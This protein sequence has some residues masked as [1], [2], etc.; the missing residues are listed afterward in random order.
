MSCSWILNPNPDPCKTMF[1]FYIIYRIIFPCYLGRAL[2]RLAFSALHFLYM[3]EKDEFVSVYCGY[4]AGPIIIMMCQK[5]KQTMQVQL[6]AVGIY[7]C[8]KRKE[9]FSEVAPLSWLPPV[10]SISL[11]ASGSWQLS[12]IPHKIP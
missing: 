11:P 6:H 2:L 9:F 7:Y 12:K 4:G 1:Y 3:K 8:I 5:H 10:T